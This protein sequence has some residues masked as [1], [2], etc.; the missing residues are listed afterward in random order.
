MTLED[1][2]ATVPAGSVREILELLLDR[3][4]ALE[5]QV[6]APPIRQGRR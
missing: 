1:K 4:K 5:E 2:I 3:I 6:A